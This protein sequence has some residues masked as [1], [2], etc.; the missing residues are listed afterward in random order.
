MKEWGKSLLKTP[1]KRGIAIKVEGYY[2]D[3]GDVSLPGFSKH[4]KD[5]SL[6][7][8]GHAE[9]LMKH[10]NKRGGRIILQNI[11]K[12]EKDDWESSRGALEA[13]L[14]LEKSVNQNLLDLRQLAE[15]YEDFQ[16]CD[17]L[18][19]EYLHEQIKEIKEVGDFISSW[20]RAGPGLGE[21]LF[22]KHEMNL[23]KKETEV[24]A[25]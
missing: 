15:K 10:Q 14:A 13:A 25:N 20:N 4:F 3:R 6:E 9:N 17:F 11:E 8:L 7:E 1:L 2:F 16:L 19:T 21:Y 5:Q 23:E 12:P 18:D 24:S 22:D